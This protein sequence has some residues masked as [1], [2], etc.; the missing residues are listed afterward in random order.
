[1]VASQPLQNS[2][3]YVDGKINYVDPDAPPSTINDIERE[4]SV[5]P[6]IAHSVRIHDARAVTNQL[7]LEG[8]GFVWMRHGTSMRNFFDSEQVLSVYYPEIAAL[9][10]SLTGARYVAVF[11]EAIRNARDEH[12][13]H[14]PVF[15][16][17]IDYD[18]R[19]LRS[20]A[21]E[22]APPDQHELLDG[23]LVLINVWRPITQIESTPLAVCDA[24][25]IQQQDLRLC[26][27]GGQSRTGMGDSSGYNLAHNPAHLWYYVSAMQPDEVLVFKICDTRREA[28]QGVGH[29][30]FVDPTSAVNAPGRQSIEIRTIAFLG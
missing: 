20:K 27:I 2:V 4:K 11:G 28:L 30:A 26:H 24:A 16:A 25:S 29:T 22:V 23:R 14:R 19:T 8:T 13:K 15:N 21:R 10:K 12:P 3:P 9:V 6:V 1:M 5:L 17:H 7:S 18:E